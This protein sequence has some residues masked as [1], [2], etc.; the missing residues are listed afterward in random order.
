MLHVETTHE[1]ALK[2]IYSEGEEVWTIA[3]GLKNTAAI[4]SQ[5]VTKSTAFL[6]KKVSKKKTT[7]I[8]DISG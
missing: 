2:F 1:T 8:P 7:D 4:S 6:Y 3:E 5:S